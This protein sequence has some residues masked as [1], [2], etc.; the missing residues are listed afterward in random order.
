MLFNQLEFAIF[1]AVTMLFLVTVKN[2][3]SQK[4][5]LLAASYYFYGYWD[6]RFLL[7]IAGCTV[8]N[9]FAAIRIGNSGNKHER[10]LW[11]T[12]ALIISLGAFGF[13]KYYNFFVDSFN[14]LGSRWGWSIGSLGIIL[15]VG[16]S[17]FTFQTLS[18]TLDVYRGQLKVRHNLLDFA[19]FVSFFPQLVAGPIVRASEFIPQLESP[20]KLTW[21]DTYEGIRIFIFGFFKKVFVADRLA[22]F[23]DVVFSDAGAFDG[24]T[25]WLSVLAYTVQIYCDFSGYSDMAIGLAQ[26]M[27]YKFSINFNFPYIARS[28]QEFWHRWHISLSTW[29]RDYLYIPLGGS[30][31]SRGRTYVNLMITML[32]GGLWHGASWA[33]VFWGGLHGVALALHRGWHEWRGDKHVVSHHH[34][35]S[36]LLGWSST[37]L[38]VMIGWVFFRASSFEQAGIILK[39]MF[40]LGEGVHWIHPFTLAAIGAVAIQHML[41]FWKGRPS[42]VDFPV[43]HWL[44][45][46]ALLLLLGLTILFYPTGFTPFIYFQ[47]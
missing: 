42:W 32:L 43:G 27:G 17:F 45:P 38:T 8:V 9:W 36:G 25:V 39:K 23:V 24:V 41:V 29:L 10:R 37:M 15:P 11:I 3:K 35:L 20:R 16:I 47:F 14:V 46:A 34:F 18:Y 26:I 4:I 40:I 31:K 33:F 12:I 6:W 21:D 19:L 28:I 7:L 13:F 5:Y 30:R 44:T 2:F 22:R 1:F